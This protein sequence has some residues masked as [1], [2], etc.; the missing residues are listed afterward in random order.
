MKYTQYD[1]FRLLDFLTELKGA[2]PVFNGSDAMTY[3][4]LEFG[5]SGGVIGVS[6]IAP[7]L[8]SSLFDEFRKGN[9][10]RARGIQL[11]LLPL[12]RAIS[13]GQFPAGV[14]EAL[15]MLGMDVGRT[16]DPVPSLLP[17][18]RQVLRGFLVQGG[19]LKESRR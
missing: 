5:G 1:F 13:V 8:A 11:K 6:N 10:D 14:K 7:S 3:T 2:I 4:N 16:K 18:E 19:L 9:L 12:I 15:K 17:A